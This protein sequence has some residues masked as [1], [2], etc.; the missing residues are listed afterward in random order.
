MCHE[1]WSLQSNIGVGSK[2]DTLLQSQAI[3]LTGVITNYQITLLER[4]LGNFQGLKI[5]ENSVYGEHLPIAVTLLITADVSGSNFWDEHLCISFSY[6]NVWKWFS[7]RFKKKTSTLRT[8][9]P[10]TTYSIFSVSCWSGWQNQCLRGRGTRKYGR[11]IYSFIQHK[12]LLLFYDSSLEGKRVSE[13]NKT[14]QLHPNRISPYQQHMHTHVRTH[15]NVHT[16]KQDTI[17][18][19][20]CSET[21]GDKSTKSH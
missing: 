15:T 13:K 19:C 14:R 6:A 16:S 20:S 1:N 21:N 18:H 8:G 9:V 17:L 2:T 12:S 5:M 11:F 10:L 7:K 3:F 4:I